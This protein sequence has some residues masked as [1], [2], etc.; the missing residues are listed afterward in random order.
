MKHG[1]LIA[2]VLALPVGSAAA[3]AP[4]M[5]SMIVHHSWNAGN[6][7]GRAVLAWVAAHAPE[8]APIGRQGAVKVAR[9]QHLP[10]TAQIG[11]SHPPGSLPQKGMPGD[12]YSVQHTLPDGAVQ[13][14]TFQWGEPSTGHGG[15]WKMN[16]YEYK[17]ANNPLNIQ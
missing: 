8:F 1:I 12:E 6:V 16:G 15:H 7:Q 17:K 2:L 10:L 3:Q 9:V 4:E 11:I 14:W 13:S 5:A